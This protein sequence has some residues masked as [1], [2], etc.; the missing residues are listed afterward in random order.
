M[1]V[2]LAL[3]GCVATDI[4]PINETALGTPPPSPEFVT[5]SGDDG[6]TV[7]ALAFSGG[8]M[9]ASAF[10]Y[11]VLRALDD[12]VVDNAPYRRTIVDN[13]R[14]VSGASG[15]AV[16]AA[17]FG[18]RGRDA[19][20]DFD[21]RFLFQ[22]AESS[23]R[24]TLLSPVVIAR[25]LSGGANDRSSF[26]RWLDDN[27]FDGARFGSLRRPNA[28]TVWINASDVFNRTPFLFSY[29]TFAALCS[30]LDSVRIS[31]AVGAS[32]AVPVVFSPIMLE[33]A[34]S[35]CDYTRP[36][37]LTRALQDPES[38]VRLQAYARA[39]DAYQRGDELKYVRLLD[40]GLTDNLGITGFVLERAA[41][42]T[43]HGPLSAE[44]AIKLRHFLFI[45]ADAGQGQTAT[46][47]RT[48]SGPKLVPVV[49]AAVST[50]MVSSVRDELDAL[51]LAV[52][53]WKQRLIQYRCGL[54]AA[55]VRRVLG[56][57][58][59]WDCR[60]VNLV[61][62][63]LAFSD[64]PPETAARLSRIPTRLSLPRADVDSLVDAGR[65]TVRINQPLARAIAD[66]R[67]QAQLS[68]N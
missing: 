61:V 31:D 37:W 21:Q 10:S 54:S 38:S 49:A 34:K 6:S 42:R 35:R 39:L 23:M 45:V 60:A 32:A 51:K 9:R 28:P 14:M 25:A 55:E 53:D 30:D 41:A 67:R 3:A 20:R 56:T 50:S 16:V 40:G 68:P 33:A 52:G 15:G 62:E 1:G 48:K 22:N 18:Y 13:I 63:H 12:I 47:G 57:S 2:S 5:D 43:P 36:A 7:V 58:R 29:D 44:Q 64:L 17:Y 4:G 59:G 46:W 26:A 11:G 66:I 8:G 24:T 65:E 27:L 19:Y